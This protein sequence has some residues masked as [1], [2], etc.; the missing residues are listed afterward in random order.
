MTDA[1]DELT[2]QQRAILLDVARLMSQR[3][4]VGEV[5][6]AFSRQLLQAAAFDYTALVMLEDDPRYVRIVGTYPFQM[7]PAIPGAVFTERSMRISSLP[8]GPEGTQYR[9]AHVGTQSGEGFAEGGFERVWSARMLAGTRTI[10]AVTVARKDAR[11]FSKAEVAFLA[12]AGQM[13]GTALAQDI[14]LANAHREAARAAL[15]NDLALLLNQG[16]P[17]DG[18]FGRVRGLL[19]GAIDFDFVSLMTRDGDAKRMVMVGTE[20]VTAR[21]VGGSATFADL[22]IPDERPHPPE[23]IQFRIDKVGSPDAP[24]FRAAGITRIA[25][26]YLETGAELIGMFSIGRRENRALTAADVAFM[27]TV[28]G[29]LSQAI[30]NERRFERAQRDAARAELLNSLALLVNAGE[31]VERLFDRILV[32]LEQ[33]IRFEYVSLMVRPGEAEALMMVGTNPVIVRPVGAVV[34]FTELAIAPRRPGDPVVRQYRPAHVDSVGGRGLAAG[35]IGRLASVVLEEDGQPMAMFSLG[36]SENQPFDAN[37]VALIETISAMLGQAIANQRRLERTQREAARAGLLNELAVLLSAG[38]PPATLFGRLVERLRPAL[39]F[40]HISLLLA[41]DGGRRVRAV[42]AITHTEAMTVDTVG[43]AY[44]IEGLPI[45]RAI[46]H[47]RLTHQFSPGRFANEMTGEVAKAGIG[48]VLTIV[49]REDDR[50]VGLLNVGRVRPEPFA[51]DEVEFTEVLGSLVGQ[52]LV[53]HLRLERAQQNAARSVLLNEIAVLLSR[54]ESFGRMFERAIELLGPVVPFDHASMYLADEAQEGRFTLVG[55]SPADAEAAQPFRLEEIEFDGSRPIRSIV[56]YF[57]PLAVEFIRPAAL[58]QGLKTGAV[59]LLQDAAD[60]FGFFSLGRRDPAGFTA[61]EAKFLEVVTTLFAQSLAQARRLAR[62]EAEAARRRLLNELSILLNNGE[63][64]GGLFSR[65]P[66]LLAEAIEFD[67]VGLAV[68]VDLSDRF[69]MFNWNRWRGPDRGTRWVDQSATNIEVIEEIRYRAFQFEPRA[70]GPGLEPEFAASGLRR[71]AVALLRH[72][73]ESVGVLNVARASG[74]PFANDEIE[75]LALVGELMAQAIAHQLRLTRSAAEAEDQRLVAGAAS[76]AAREPNPREITGELGESLRH[77]VP[78]AMVAYALVENGQ[79][80]ISDDALGE[81]TLSIGPAIVKAIDLGQAAGRVAERGLPRKVREQLESLGVAAWSASAALV[82]GQV[83]GLLVVVSRRAGYRFGERELRLLREIAQAIGPAISNAVAEER[84]RQEAREQRILADVA[85]VAAREAGTR[86]LAAALGPLAAFIPDSSIQFAFIDGDELLCHEPDGTTRHLPFGPYVRA[87]I[88]EGQVVVQGLP[89]DLSP[90]A[91][92]MLGADGVKNH[93]LTAARSAG[94]T[95]GIL[96]AGTRT[97]DHVF[98]ARDCALLERVASIVGP[99]MANGLAAER[100]AAE[101]TEQRIVAA[102]AA[103]AASESNPHKLVSAVL[104]PLLELV[105]RPFL[106]Y[107]YIE[108]QETVYPAPDGRVERYPRGALDRHVEEL[109]QYVVEEHSEEIVAL[110]RWDVQCVVGTAA[111]AGGATVGILI[112]GSRQPGYSFGERELRIFRLVAQIIGAGM[113]TARAAQRAIQEAEEQRL[114]AGIAAV[115]AREPDDQALLLGIVE[116]LRRVIPRPAISFAF[117][118]GD[119]AVHVAPARGQRMALHPAE[120]LARDSGQVTLDVM[121]EDLPAEHPGRT[122]AAQSAIVT[123]TYSA[124]H[125]TGLLYI[126]SR[127]RAYVF[128]EREERLFR[129]VAQIVGP[130]MENARRAA[131]AARLTALYQLMFESLSEAVILLDHDLRAVFSNEPGE[132]IIRLIDPARRLRTVDDHVAHMPS[133]VG[134]AFRRALETNEP[135]RGRGEFAEGGAD[136]A[137]YDFE[138]V[139]LDDPNY[140]LLIVA[141][142]VTE[143]VERE[144]LQE[145]Q[146][147]Q[148]QQASRLAALGELIGGVAHELNNPLTAILGFAE[149]LSLSAANDAIAEEVGIIQKEAL[150][151]RNIVRDLLLIARPGRVEPSLVDL[152]GVVDH[153]ERLRRNS[154]AQE[155]ID[156]TMEFADAECHAWGN[157]NQLTQVLLNLVTNA[158]HATEGREHRTIAIRARRAAGQVVLE[159]GDNGG[160]MDEVTAARVFEPFFTTKQGQ[161]TGLG[162]SMSYSIIRAHN[163]T[164]EV[165]TSAGQGT[166]FR[167]TLPAAPA[168]P[169]PIPAEPAAPATGR[170]R[171]LVVD[172]EPSLRKVCQRLVTSMGHDCTVAG[173]A[174][175]AIDRASAD[176]PDLI[177]CDY[178]LAAETADEVVNGIAERAPGLV[179]RIVIATGATTDAGVVRLTERFGLRLI[180]KPYGFDEIARLIQASAPASIA[181]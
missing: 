30:A 94:A 127:E 177:L 115:A 176:A 117:V 150:R 10:G 75:F 113:E 68:R 26:I 105:P 71:V 154:W 166:T 136:G 175:E 44:A 135:L 45:D 103:A 138:M 157:E 158:E 74:R 111:R 134:E 142:D 2:G 116:P 149:V 108:G 181:S 148:M 128:T 29:M 15:L 38:E 169:A 62:V 163:G 141:T 168:Q 78:E 36:R 102:I 19:E 52:A 65:L 12:Q 61:E 171:V 144:R 173:T 76:L 100:S 156:V 21:E 79:V 4:S 20:P 82:G 159:V 107:G 145:E 97:T 33:A 147:E 80:V 119:E 99:A 152:H 92:A 64:V 90:A 133:A 53:N 178:R 129:L 54:G 55:Y 139:P 83:A 31:P 93:V 40:D 84:A 130:A 101:A 98:S 8:E 14:E 162:L 13:L 37:D 6:A 155:R 121:P 16:E 47:G 170:V 161:G 42:G 27:A 41:E 46:G 179:G 25:S 104:R 56:R 11:R 124:G 67:Q 49:L 114:L 85:A 86:A 72:S 137:W 69:Q 48:R 43:V 165:Q 81:E 120:L 57:D 146:R 143:A 39:P 131:E 22:L 34:S 1:D 9:P 70:D 59:C 3:R 164:I 167:I 5:F 96:V 106:A 87:A 23:V 17:I 140:R 125:P 89:G 51:P 35:G 123:A 63:P 126:G 122:V 174:T 180:A 132:L 109:G 110:Q 60:F 32:L 28:G 58:A 95:I 160:G 50:F 73:S 91:R 18:V 24:T 151:A 172:D 118:D 66:E 153:V 88:E 7:P 77:L 112:T